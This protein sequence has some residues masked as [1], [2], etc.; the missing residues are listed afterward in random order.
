ML[1]RYAFSSTGL[2]S[3][4]CLPHTMIAIGIY[5]FNNCAVL[6][7]IG[8]GFSP[9][10]DVRPDAVYNYPALLAAAQTKGFSTA[11]E[12]G[13]HHWLAFNRVNCRLFVLFSV[14]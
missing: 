5:A 3:L 11:I 12:W 6:T 9:D 2:T 8:P 13:K 10:C 7:S 1:Q 14:R 4:E